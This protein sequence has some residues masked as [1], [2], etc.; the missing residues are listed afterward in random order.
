MEPVCLLT[1]GVLFLAHTHT[2]GI[3]P[4]VQ[5]TVRGMAALQNEGTLFPFL[6]YLMCTTLGHAEQQTGTLHWQ[7]MKNLVRQCT[8]EQAPWH[9]LFSFAP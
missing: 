7:S 3:L 6:R 8:D 5:L 1:L 4:K 2:L 9:R